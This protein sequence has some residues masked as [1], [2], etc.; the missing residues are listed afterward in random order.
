MRHTLAVRLACMCFQVMG[1][2]QARHFDPLGAAMAAPGLCG[3]FQ[4]SGSVYTSP[5]VF[6]MAFRK[7]G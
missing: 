7:Y 5:N 1:A 2:A 4:G 6:T 3:S